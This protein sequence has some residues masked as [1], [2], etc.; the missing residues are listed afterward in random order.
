MNNERQRRKSI[1]EF[2]ILSSAAAI[3]RAM[4][5]NE[6]VL[7]D[8]TEE[9]RIYAFDIQNWVFRH[10]RRMLDVNHAPMGVPSDEFIRRIISGEFDDSI[11]AVLR[12][13]AEDENSNAPPTSRHNEEP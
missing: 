8:L 11:S 2:V 10:V 5:L 4:P 6:I 1:K 7:G 13:L 12:R 3:T 9:E